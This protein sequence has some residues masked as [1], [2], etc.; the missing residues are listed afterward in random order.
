MTL[1]YWVAQIRDDHPCYSIRA[2]TR[3][4]VLSRM[5]SIGHD[6]SN[7]LPPKKVSIEYADGF[8]LLRQC[9]SS[10]LVWWEG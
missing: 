7:Y 1:T 5:A 2:K 3:K 10:D 6:P 4:A 9:V 8:D